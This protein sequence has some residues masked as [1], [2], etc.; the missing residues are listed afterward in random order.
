MKTFN[1]RGFLAG[2]V[3]LAGLTTFAQ[4]R[5]LAAALALGEEAP[6]AAKPA[7]EP[8]KLKINDRAKG[9]S[10]KRTLVLPGP[11]KKLFKRYEWVADT[12]CPLTLLRSPDKP[13]KSEKGFAWYVGVDR[14]NTA[15]CFITANP[16]SEARPIEFKTEKMFPLTPTYYRVYSP[17][18]GKSWKRIAFEPPHSSISGCPQTMPEPYRIEVPAH[19]YQVAVVRLK[20]SKK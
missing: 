18:G 17:D 14:R 4:S 16:S 12:V 1:R 3:S 11:A 9:D 6:D 19:S 5:L 20:E 8:L 10:S 7:P 15:I 13:D 2:A